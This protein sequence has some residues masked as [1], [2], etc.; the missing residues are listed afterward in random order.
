VTTVAIMQPY[1][2]PY[3]GYYQLIAQ[4]DVFVLLDDVQ[5]M[6]GGW[7]NRNR[8]LVNGAPHWLTF[9]VE[10]API[11]LSIDQRAY[12]AS[13]ANRGK[14]LNALANAYRKAPQ[15]AAT[16]EAA[17]E[18]MAYEDANVAGFNR[19]LLTRV[20]RMLGIET[21]I[22]AASELDR[23][24]GLTGQERVLDLCRR[25]GAD[26]YVNAPGGAGLYD[27]DAF[28]AVGIAL[29]F[30][31]SVA[32]PYPQFG[33][34]FVPFLSILDV[35]MFNPPEAAALLLDNYELA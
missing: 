10:H 1:F 18:I 7:I 6:K 5:Y 17:A 22:L 4:S 26:T 14:V 8:I 33:Q 31:K 9:P 19:N 23:T 2:F 30:L 29:R 3:I 15:A 12:Q 11:Q 13:D 20:A 24:P 25:L 21:P 16:L 27:G 34:P 32:E 28:A 35:M